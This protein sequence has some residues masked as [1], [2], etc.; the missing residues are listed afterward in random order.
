MAEQQ[1]FANSLLKTEK[2][3]KDK[4]KKNKKQAPKKTKEKEKG[5]N[6]P[7]PTLQSID[8]EDKPHVEFE[9]DTEIIPEEPVSLS[10]EKKKEKKEKVT[11]FLNDVTFSGN[12]SFVIVTGQTHFE[13][14]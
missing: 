4:D 1:Q 13:K 5:K 2:S 7:Q 14:S 12:C 8:F 9:P 10:Q 11:N 3:H 6:Q